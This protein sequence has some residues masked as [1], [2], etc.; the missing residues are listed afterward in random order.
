MEY[1]PTGFFLFKFEIMK[2][3]IIQHPTHDNFI[4]IRKWYQDLVPEIKGEGKIN[5][6]CAAALMSLFEYWYNANLAGNRRLESTVSFKEINESLQ[7][8]F[9]RNTIIK[10]LDFLVDF[11]ILFVSSET[12]TGKRSYLFN[13]ERV[14][15]LSMKVSLKKDEVSL[16]LNEVSL[17]KDEVSLKK[18]YIKDNIKDDIKKNTKE[19]ILPNV[20]KKE[21]ETTEAL[22]FLADNYKKRNVNI[23]LLANRAIVGKCLNKFSLE[24]IKRGIFYSIQQKIGKEINGKSLEQYIKVSTIFAIEN[25]SKYVSD[26]EGQEMTTDDDLEKIINFGEGNK[27]FYGKITGDW[28]VKIKGMIA[29]ILSE[30]EETKKSICELIRFAAKTAEIWK[31]WEFLLRNIKNLRRIYDKFGGVA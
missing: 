20:S 6:G 3:S 30:G 25:M 12:Q 11:K 29:E 10:A 14:N 28:K 26:S 2:N 7:G 13:H 21:L 5:K 17:K 4:M 9:G 27:Y 18:D 23:D 19:V 31:E 24:D 8:L 1:L 16:N 15:E 22:L